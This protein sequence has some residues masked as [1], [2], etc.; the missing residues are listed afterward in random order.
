[1]KHKLKTLPVPFT[2]V[3]EGEKNFEV[4]LNDRDYK[5]GD[6]LRLCEYDFEHGYYGREISALVTYLIEL[7]EFLPV[8]GYV[9]MS[10]KLISKGL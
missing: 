9:G 8:K 1:M 2:A 5:V 10:I 3:W 4:R 6:M 7:D